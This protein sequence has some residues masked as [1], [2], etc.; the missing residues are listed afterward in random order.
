MPLAVAQNTGAAVLLGNGNIYLNGAQLSNSNAIVAGDVVQT[1]ENGSGMISGAGPSVGLDS[2][3][4][5][6]F[7]GAD[8]A[9]DRGAVKIATGQQMGVNARDL[10]I[11]PTSK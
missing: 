10:K 9:L 8:V 6:R 1:K 4:I 11:V 7:Q 2:N 5:V 3:A